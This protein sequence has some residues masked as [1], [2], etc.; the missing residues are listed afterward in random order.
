M[1]QRE[2]GLPQV[3]IVDDEVNFLKLVDHWL[4]SRYEVTCLTG[5]EDVVDSIAALAPDLLILDIHLPEGSGFEIC[6]RLRKRPGF[7]DLPVIFLTGSKTDRDFLLYLEFGGCR[8][9]TKPV[10]GRELCEAI[11]EELGLKAVG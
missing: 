5:G 11:S 7:E 8:Y 1:D 6:R 2:T 4:K 3:V 9:M 10:T